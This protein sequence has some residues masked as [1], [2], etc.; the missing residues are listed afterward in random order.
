MTNYDVV[1]KLIG[2]IKP[3]GE[4]YADLQNKNRTEIYLSSKYTVR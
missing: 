2:E 3:I 4:T 1:K